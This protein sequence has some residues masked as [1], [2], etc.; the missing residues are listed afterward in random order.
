MISRVFTSW[1]LVPR[2][3]FVH[4]LSFTNRLLLFQ[5]W[6]GDESGAQNPA[7]AQPLVQVVQRV[8]TAERS[9]RVRRGD[10]LGGRFVHT[11]SDRP[12]RR[13]G[14]P[15]VQQGPTGAQVHGLPEGVVPQRQIH[16]YGA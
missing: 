16:I 5:L 7:D 15:A 12:T 1:C 11:G 8:V 10:Q 13:P 3:Y 2:S 6:P 14:T 9:R 4:R